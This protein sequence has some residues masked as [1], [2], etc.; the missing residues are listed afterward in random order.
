[1]KLWTNELNGTLLVMTE[2]ERVYE[3]SRGNGNYLHIRPDKLT[4]DP[5]KQEEI[6]FKKLFNQSGC[7][8]R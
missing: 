4:P 5:S 1:M 3:V 8:H 6:E 7:Y 2:D